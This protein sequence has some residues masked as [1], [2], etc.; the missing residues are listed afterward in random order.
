VPTWLV[1]LL[2]IYGGVGV[3]AF[4]ALMLFGMMASHPETAEAPTRSELWDITKLAV[5][6]AIGWP[7]LLAFAL[8]VIAI[9]S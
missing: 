6:G 5:L 9:E 7:C 3:V 2:S 1:I 4:V 8:F